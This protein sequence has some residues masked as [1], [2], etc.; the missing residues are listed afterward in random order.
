MNTDD[1]DGWGNLFALA[2]GAGQ[3]GDVGGSSSTAPIVAV[4]AGESLSLS[5]SYDDVQQTSSMGDREEASKKR[6]RGKK[7][8]K[9]NDPKKN[10]MTQQQQEQMKIQMKLYLEGRMD[11]QPPADLIP[12]WITPAPANA[13]ATNCQ[14][15]SQVRQQQADD[16]KAAITTRYKINEGSCDTPTWPLS[17]FV[18]VLNLRSYHKYVATSCCSLM[19]ENTL[20]PDALSKVYHDRNVIKQLITNETKALAALLSC[21]D[22]TCMTYRNHLLGSCRKVTGI[23][24]K[25]NKSN[26]NN[27]EDHDGGESSKNYKEDDIE[28]FEAAVLSVMKCDDLYF[29]LYYAQITNSLPIS[30]SM[31]GATTNSEELVF[32]PHPLHYFRIVQTRYSNDETGD[33]ETGQPTRDEQHPLEIIYHLR[34]KEA[35]ELLNR[36]A[37]AQ[38][39]STIKSWKNIR[40]TISNTSTHMSVDELHETPAPHLLKIW[41][42]SNRD[43]LCHL[44]CYATVP[45]KILCEVE[46]LMQARN[47]QSIVE[48]GAGTGYLA[49]LFS[50]MRITVD[51]YD[52]APTTDGCMLKHERITKPN[53]YHGLVPSFYTVKKWSTSSSLRNNFPSTNTCS[54]SVLL[55]CYP[56]PGSSMAFDTLTRFLNCNGDFLIFVGEFKGL[57]GSN[58]FENL[59][60]KKV[61]CI[62]RQDCLSWGTD[63]SQ[64]SFWKIRRQN[65]IMNSV[66]LPCVGCSKNE[67][68][69]RCRYLRN[70]CYCSL[71]CFEK[72]KNAFAASLDQHSVCIQ[73]II[74]FDQQDFVE[75]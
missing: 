9:N 2:A 36:S 65:L 27:N 45:T 35:D 37:W 66:L 39:P 38:H 29:R 70:M 11:T 6:K 56:P 69:K 31:A 55:L 64:I 3:A 18:S 42:D 63:A 75:L 49:A 50:K 10:M 15:S 30:R 47:I 7:S 25:S 26:N 57:T 20:P 53:E 74:R 23:L 8:K 33:A 73:G 1:E 16:V 43:F 71:S 60:Q 52:A 68:V 12:S 61:N 40:K 19:K 58:H 24:T 17:M 46:S 28:L 5:N 22:E 44:Y 21:N 32:I 14:A 59:L 41:R 4:A 13:N 48:I 62:Y 67:S 54:N 34:K 72:N 51:A